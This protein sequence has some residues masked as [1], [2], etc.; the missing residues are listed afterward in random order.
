MEVV[1]VLIEKLMEVE[2][3]VLSSKKLEKMV[4]ELYKNIYK[5][6]ELWINGFVMEISFDEIGIA[7]K[8]I[9][10]NLEIF[11][12]SWSEIDEE[13]ILNLYLNGGIL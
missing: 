8:A 2:K 11:T 9:E 6:N 12:Q 13:E 7:S 3:L 1:Q 10:N 4:P 5:E